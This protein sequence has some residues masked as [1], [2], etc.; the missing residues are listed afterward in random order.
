MKTWFE[1]EQ[2]GLRPFPFAKHIAVVESALEVGFFHIGSVEF[3]GA[4][5]RF[6]KRG[7]AQISPAKIAC[8]HIGSIKATPLFAPPNRLQQTTLAVF[9]ATKR[10]IS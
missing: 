9:W 6:H 7:M 1:E 4:N 8:L 10:R 2:E 3:D 5:G